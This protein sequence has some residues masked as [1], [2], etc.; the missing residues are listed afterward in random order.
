MLKVIKSKPIEQHFD[1]RKIQN[2]ICMQ[3]QMDD[4]EM[5]QHWKHHCHRRLVS[6]STQEYAKTCWNILYSRI[7]V[8]PPG[9]SKKLLLVWT[10]N[11]AILFCLSRNNININ[12]NRIFFIRRLSKSLHHANIVPQ[13]AQPLTSK[14][15][16]AWIFGENP[17][18]F[19]PL[20]KP[21]KIK[22]MIYILSESF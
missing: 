8:W 2:C 5:I 10:K 1:C 20:E 11:M 13:H 22:L 16:F 18:L 6:K 3:P 17:N 21:I 15:Y 14:K 9:H 7:E 4:Q 12:A 19:W